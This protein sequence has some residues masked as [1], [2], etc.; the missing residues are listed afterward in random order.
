MRLLKGSSR[1]DPNPCQ[2]SD[3]RGPPGWTTRR[4]KRDVELR[5][6]RNALQR[7]ICHRLL[8]GARA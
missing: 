1:L 3:Q 5:Y 4:V 8:I 2:T 7:P 6:R